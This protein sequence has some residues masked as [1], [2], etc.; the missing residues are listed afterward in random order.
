MRYNAGIDDRI[1]KF[2]ETELLK[3]VKNEDVQRVRELLEN[4]ANPNLEF[5]IESQILMDDRVKIEKNCFSILNFIT[6][7]H[8]TQ[9]AELLLQHNAQVNLPNRSNWTPLHSA[10]MNLNKPIADLLIANGANT[11]ALT[12]KYRELGRPV[13]PQ[14]VWA[15]EEKIAASMQR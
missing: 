2:H 6:H 4:G 8:N 3:A 12:D 11:N 1:S 14:E 10:C 5:W 15:N 13:T 7:H 9:I